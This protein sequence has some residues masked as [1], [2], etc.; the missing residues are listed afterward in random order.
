MTQLSTRFLFASATLALA[1]AAMAQGT[2]PNAAVPNPATGAGQQSQQGTPMGTTGTP[3]TNSGAAPM[4]NSGTATMNSST[5]SPSTGS[6]GDMGNSRP[7][8]AARADRN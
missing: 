2:P 3:A 8:R 1:S 6:S 7:M 5:T 4:T